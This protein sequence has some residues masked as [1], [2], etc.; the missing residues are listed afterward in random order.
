MF[1]SFN[2]GTTKEESLDSV[3]KLVSIMGGLAITLWV[4]AY[5]SHS[6]LTKGS[7]L[8]VRR[9][10]KAYLDAVLRQES[11][12]FDMSNYTELS[13]RMAAE[14]KTIEVGIGQ[15]YG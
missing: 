12:W 3:G 7:L 14:C 10:K 8:V 2:E 4:T 6:Q 15:K 5:L 9:I 13:T 1:E 11:A